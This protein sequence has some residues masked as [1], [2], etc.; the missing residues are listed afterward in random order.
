MTS[1]TLIVCGA[2]VTVALVS[3]S[4]ATA[5]WTPK[6]I[7]SDGSAVPRT[8]WGDPDLQGHWNNSTTTPVERLTSEEQSQSR[9]A[10]QAVIE[11][12][13]GT[14]AGWLEQA[15]RIARESLIIDPPDGRI[16][17]TDQ[18]VQRLIDRENAR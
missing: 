16:R 9:R 17:M 6:R 18:S 13:G 2:V 1:R 14:G 15:G 10:Q 7:E 5:Q 12:T 11:A 3:V 4:P 8:P